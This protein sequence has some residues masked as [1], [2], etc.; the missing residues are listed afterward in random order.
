MTSVVDGGMARPHAATS[1][2]LAIDPG[3]TPIG[4]ALVVIGGD[5]GRAQV[6]GP[7]CETGLI[8]R[9]KGALSPTGFAPR[10]RWT[11]PVSA[12][13]SGRRWWGGERICDPP[14]RRPS[15]QTAPWSEPR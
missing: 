8:H 5:A 10:N 3:A 1:A 6:Q 2:S 12:G 7:D 9:L 11:P 15:V 14:R 4:L 13:P